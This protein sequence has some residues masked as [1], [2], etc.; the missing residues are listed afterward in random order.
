MF[1]WISWLLSSS[2][3]EDIFTA[4]GF[5][6]R[7]S[8]SY[9]VILGHTWSFFPQLH[10]FLLSP[11]SLSRPLGNGWQQM[12]ILTVYNFTFI[13]TWILR[14]CTL[15]MYWSTYIWWWFHCNLIL[16]VISIIWFLITLAVKYCQPCTGACHWYVIFRIGDKIMHKYIFHTTIYFGCVCMLLYLENHKEATVGVFRAYGSFTRL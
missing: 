11:F 1:F 3:C 10:S 9:L 16:T 6:S 5:D 7:A 4:W 15:Y 14:H 13:G 8:W 2:L 12:V